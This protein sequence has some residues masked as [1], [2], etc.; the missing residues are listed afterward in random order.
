MADLIFDVVFSLILDMSALGEAD[1]LPTVIGNSCGT[2]SEKEKQLRD[3][4]PPASF[5]EFVVL[6]EA[7][8]PAQ[9]VSALRLAAQITGKV[10]VDMGIVLK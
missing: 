7:A 8:S 6:F 3:I 1:L 5:D 2:F 10:A 4:Y 9:L